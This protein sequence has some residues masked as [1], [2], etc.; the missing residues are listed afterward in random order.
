MTIHQLAT[1][2]ESFA[3]QLREQENT[4]LRKHPMARNRDIWRSVV[5]VRGERGTFVLYPERH[6][7]DATS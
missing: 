7:D 5:E 1:I 4:E 3:K 2:L 6:L